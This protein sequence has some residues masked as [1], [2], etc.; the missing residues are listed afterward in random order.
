MAV[1]EV[2]EYIYQIRYGTPILLSVEELIGCNEPRLPQ[3]KK[4]GTKVKKV[5]DGVG[6]YCLTINS[7]F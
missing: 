7:A 5:F 3:L 6:C 4:D 2:V 1:V